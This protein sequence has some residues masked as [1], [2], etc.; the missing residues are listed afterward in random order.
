LANA[1]LEEVTM[2]QICKQVYE[3]Y[4]AYDLTEWK[5]FIKTTVKEL[6]SWD[7]GQMICSHRFEDLIYT[8]IPTKRMYFL[9]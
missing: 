8:I 7:R 3:N 6:I 5:D 9:F 2:K 1:N 4:P